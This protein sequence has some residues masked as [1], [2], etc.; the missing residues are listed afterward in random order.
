LK[1]SNHRKIFFFKDYF[2]TFF[3]R[4]TI[5]IKKKIIWTFDLLEDLNQIPST[6]LKR[7]HDTDDLY[8]IRVQH[9]SDIVRI[10][11]L[12]DEGN[13]IVLLNGFNKKSQK[14]PRKEILSA[15][16]IRKE[17]FYEKESD[18]T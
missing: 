6:Y 3:E 5:R 7:I 17:Y 11:C 4:Q 18:I 1:N 8:E 14:T 9:G 10:F 16:R 12:F 13:L 15:L 2:Q